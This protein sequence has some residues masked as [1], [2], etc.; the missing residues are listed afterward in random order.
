[1]KS[2]ADL[3]DDEKA[4][5]HKLAEEDKARYEKECAAAETKRKEANRKKGIYISRS[6]GRVPCVGLDNG[7]TSYET[8][9][10]AEDFVAY[11][12]TDKIYPVVKSQGIV[13]KSITVN[14]ITYRHNPA[15]GTKAYTAGRGK[16]RKFGQSDFIWH[17][18]NGPK[19]KYTI[20]NNYKGETWREDH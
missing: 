10:P 16:Y 1:M 4:P 9:G 17:V 3:S 7:F 20:Y 14:G 5:F 2:W 13:W 18:S 12:A 6:Y 11:A 15:A 19:A 8:I